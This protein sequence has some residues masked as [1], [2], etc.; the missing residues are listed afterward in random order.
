M[1]AVVDVCATAAVDASRS[2]IGIA[3]KL[4]TMRVSLVERA[5][6]IVLL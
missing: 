1:V 4:T 5:R 2:A 6:N 3:L